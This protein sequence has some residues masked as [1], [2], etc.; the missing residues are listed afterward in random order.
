M[1][2]RFDTRMAAFAVSGLACLAA[3]QAQTPA[4]AEVDFAYLALAVQR[5]IPLS[6]LDQPPADEGI[7]GAR[8]GLADDETTGRFIHQTYRLA[9]AI[10]PDEV[11]V[12]ASFRKFAAAGQR[13]FVTDLPAALLLQIADLPEAKDA[14]LLDA[15]AEDDMLRA[16]GCRPNVLHL[17][18]SRAMLADAL[19]QYLAVKKWRNILLVS[20]PEAGDKAYA[21]AL[22]HAAAKFQIHIVQDKPW[23]YDPGARRTDTGHYAIEAEVAR[24]T[25]GIGYDVLVVADEGDNF[26]D[27][28]A[29]RATDPRPVAGTQGLVPSAWARPFE[30]WGGTQ[31]QS[32]F[33]RQAGRWMTDRDYGA[34][35]A[36]RALGE[37]AARGA[38]PDAKQIGTFLRSPDF[39]LAAFKG[40]RL[41]FR[42]WDGQLRQPVLLADARSLVSVSP[43]PGFL[44][45]FSELDTLGTDQPETSCHLN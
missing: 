32:R 23:T 15:T 36:V 35:M 29:Y 24:F 44:H 21:D 38:G 34:W 43:Q 22:R 3:A 19:M 20:G 1:R 14:I 11:S 41:T 16:D 28:L 9:E 12:L 13:L 37:A 6:Y 39:E 42:A 40:A 7:Q 17:L 27:D 18:P 2:L 4:P 31:L 45:Q 8:L 30:Q 10:E 25:Q 5:T 33:L 26:G